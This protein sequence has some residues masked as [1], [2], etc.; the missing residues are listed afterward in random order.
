MHVVIAI[1]KEC[2]PQI[3]GGFDIFKCARDRARDECFVYHCE[4]P[5]STNHGCIDKGLIVIIIG[6]PWQ[7]HNKAT[8][9]TRSRYVRS[10]LRVSVR[11]W[12]ASVHKRRRFV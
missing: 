3:D 12:R 5:F 2:I 4:V 7:K 6:L 10:A 11:G 9:S 1:E 8:D